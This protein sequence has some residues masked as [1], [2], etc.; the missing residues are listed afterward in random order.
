MQTVPRGIE[1]FLGVVSKCTERSQVLEAI[2]FLR[3]AKNYQCPTVSTFALHLILDLYDEDSS[4]QAN[5]NRMTVRL[6]ATAEELTYFSKLI[7]ALC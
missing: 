6:E 3:M 4:L 1:M 2:Q 7:R 5:I